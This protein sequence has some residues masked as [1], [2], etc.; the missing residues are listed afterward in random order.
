[1]TFVLALV[2]VGLVSLGLNRLIAFED[3]VI[4]LMMVVITI[5]ISSII[6]NTLIY[7]LIGLQIIKI[8]MVAA[9]KYRLIIIIIANTFHNRL[10][11]LIITLNSLDLIDLYLIIQ[12]T[13]PVLLILIINMRISLRPLILILA[14]L[15]PLSPIILP[16]SQ[17]VSPTHQPLLISPTLHVQ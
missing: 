12:L 10:I 9:L 4:H 14:H 7:R 17:I 13:Q 8:I 5:I 2:F 1:M 3:R 15:Y 16:T 11:S 6:K